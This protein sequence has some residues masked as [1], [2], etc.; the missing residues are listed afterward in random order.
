MSL[1]D[2]RKNPRRPVTYP[3]FIDVG[4]G[5]PAVECLLCDASQEGAQLAVADC[6]AVPNEFILA[7]S[8]DGA[9]R[10]RCRVMWRADHYVGVEFLRDSGKDSKKGA[11]RLWSTAIK[12]SIP[13]AAHAGEQEKIDIETLPPR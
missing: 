7:L 9:A 13:K 12:R 4:N 8:S 3:A 1:G 6:D 10:R 5:Q 2:K 11:H